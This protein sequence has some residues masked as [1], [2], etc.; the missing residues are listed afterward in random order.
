MCSENCNYLL[1]NILP[2]GNYKFVFMWRCFRNDHLP[3][4]LKVL[5]KTIHDIPKNVIE[6][7]NAICSM[8]V[9]GCSCCQVDIKMTVRQPPGEKKI[10]NPVS[11]LKKRFF[12]RFC[13]LLSCLLESFLQ[14]DCEHLSLFQSHYRFCVAIS[15]S[16]FQ[17][18]NSQSKNIRRIIGSFCQCEK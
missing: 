10:A 3:I 13:Q 17:G 11:F 12:E 7:T 14:V 16:G 9:Q 8:F 6:N 1:N 18:S 4:Y 5:L 2:T 15:G